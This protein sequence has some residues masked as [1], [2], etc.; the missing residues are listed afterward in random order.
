KKRTESKVTARPD[1]EAWMMKPTKSATP[2][3]ASTVERRERSFT[4]LL[5]QVQ[6]DRLPVLRR[7]VEG[8]LLGRR[9]AHELAVL[10]LRQ[11]VAGR[12]FALGDVGGADH[13]T[14]VEGRDLVQLGEEGGAGQCVHSTALDDRLHGLV[15]QQPG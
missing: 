3:P 8:P 11:H 4:E 10:H 15:D 5:E 14:R 6:L 13:A 7:A 12:D 9:H 1:Q 2:S